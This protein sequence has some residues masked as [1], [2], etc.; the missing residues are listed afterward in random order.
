MSA[1]IDTVLERS[2][3]YSM[4]QQSSLPMVESQI[5]T[6]VVQISIYLSP[7]IEIV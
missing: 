2:A 3:P 7:V 4:I 1:N 6:A 5:P